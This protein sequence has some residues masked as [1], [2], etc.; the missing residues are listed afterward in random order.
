MEYLTPI[1]DTAIR[2]AR[3]AGQIILEQRNALQ[4]DFKSATEV[5]TGTDRAAE[6][7]IVATIRQAFPDHEFFAEESAQR[8]SLVA[9]R[10]WIIDPLDGT[11]NFANGIPQ[12]AVS[13]AFAQDGV[14]KAGVVFDPVR[15]ELFSAIRGQGASM[16]G[17]PIHVSGKDELRHAI[18]ATGF[19]YD[20]GTLMVNTLNTVRTLFEQGIRGIRR[21]GSAALDLSWVACGRFDA[22]FEYSLCKWDFA[23]GALILEEA[24]GAL[25]SH[26]GGPF[27]LDATGAITS[28]GLLHDRMLAL[29]TW[30]KDDDAKGA[31]KQG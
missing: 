23:A 25:S 18:V 10:L 11:S 27:T 9:P 4:V 2:A 19:A 13:I 7:S 15:D 31:Q 14:V 26:T 5:V 20:R 17:C 30:P 3:G 1:L 24:G 22:Y 28:N 6:A 16:N 12:Y 29:T 21:F 8:A